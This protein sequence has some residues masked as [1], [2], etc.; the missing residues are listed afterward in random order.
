MTAVSRPRGKRGLTPGT[1]HRRADHRRWR[2]RQ[3]ARIPARVR[4]RSEVG[5][6]AEAY[7]RDRVGRVVLTLREPEPEVRD[8]PVGKV[9]RLLDLD[10]RLL[11]D[12]VGELPDA[13]LGLAAQPVDLRPRD[14]DL[15]ERRVAGGVPRRD[16]L[17]ERD[18]RLLRDPDERL[19]LRELLVHAV[20]LHDVLL[21]PSLLRAPEDLLQRGL[22]AGEVVGRRL[23]LVAFGRLAARGGALGEGG[24]REHTADD[25]DEKESTVHGPLPTPGEPGAEKP[26][27]TTWFG[28]GPSTLGPLHRPNPDGENDPLVVWLRRDLRLLAA[29]RRAVLSAVRRRHGATPAITALHEARRHLL[30]ALGKGLR[31][32]VALPGEPVPHR[33][34]VRVLALRDEVA[35][36]RLAGL[37]DHR[38][39]PDD[40]GAGRAVRDGAFGRRRRARGGAV[41]GGGS[42]APPLTLRELGR[43]DPGRIG[44]GGHRPVVL[45]PGVGVGHRVVVQVGRGRL[46]AAEQ[47]VAAPRHLGLDDELRGGRRAVPDGELRRRSRALRRAVKRPCLAAPLLAPP[48]DARRERRTPLADRDRLVVA[49]PPVA[50][51][52]GLLVGVALRGSRVADDRLPRHGRGGDEGDRGRGGRRVPHDRGGAGGLARHLAVVWRHLDAPGL[53]VAQDG[54]RDDR[55]IVRGLHAVAEPEV[56]IGDLVAVPIRGRLPQR[57]RD[58]ARRGGLGGL[59]RDRRRGRRRVLHLALAVRGRAREV[60]VPGRHDDAHEVVLAERDRGRARRGVGDDRLMT[61]GGAIGLAVARDHLD[62]PALP[63]LRDA[64]R[65]LGLIGRCVDLLPVARPRVP[66]GEDVAVRIGRLLDRD[67]DPVHAARPLRREEEARRR[68]R[69]VH[70]GR[71]GARERT[72]LLAVMSAHLDEPALPLLELLRRHLARARP[73]RRRLRGLGPVGERDG[74][75]VADPAVLVPDRVAG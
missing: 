1:R 59:E 24:C 49:V 16:G 5:S 54:G 62:G 39:E 35:A 47:L 9:R 43:L 66:V 33:V 27:E 26:F 42:A 41:G 3:A 2:E 20:E 45:G 38:L 65:D 46:D 18:V 32:P 10:R 72:S 36:D 6:G 58:A 61:H 11:V 69:A 73:E 55:L 31:R 52:D 75:A 71:R 15:R 19:D 67:H 48:D 30:R 28:D 25:E 34:T 53:P 17:V 23:E 4:A 44:A 64:A 12:H 7:L 63:L 14:R 56:T 21:V 50:E 70:D 57:D 40:R 22:H 51:R 8:A 68:G 74:R 29:G 37:R 60:A 13:L